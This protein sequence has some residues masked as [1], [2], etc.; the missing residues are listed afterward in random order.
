MEL[1][2]FDL[3]L[4]F[5]LAFVLS[6]IVGFNVIYLVNSKLNDLQINVPACPQP[7]CPTPV[8]SPVQYPYLIDNKTNE[9]KQYKMKQD[10]IEKFESVKS[11]SS[12]VLETTGSETQLQAQQDNIS[13]Y[14]SDTMESNNQKKENTINTCRPYTGRSIKENS[15]NTITTG[16][17]LP[18][19]NDPD[20]IVQQNIQMY[21]P[22]VYM[23][24]IPSLRQSSNPNGNN[25]PYISGISYAAMDL[26]I[27]ADIDQIG[28]IP[29]NDSNAD[30]VPITS[31]MSDSR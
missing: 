30:P 21:V 17:M 22:S 25:D 3:L 15:Y 31:T 16:F 20:N 18:S 28:S 6:L 2:V 8:C 11:P 27:P 10:K 9:I 13:G 5:I 7:V 12:D 24:G 4:L 19:S 29:I 14:D 1:Q 23:N 26:E